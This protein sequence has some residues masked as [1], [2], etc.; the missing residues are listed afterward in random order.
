M[1]AVAYVA[2]LAALY[3]WYRRLRPDL[4]MLAGGVLSLIVAVTCFLSYHLLESGSGSFL[5]IGLVVI[6]MSAGGA[7]W[8]KSVAREQAA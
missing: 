8:I 1:A 3:G 6:G 4:F 5:L 7:I 2:W